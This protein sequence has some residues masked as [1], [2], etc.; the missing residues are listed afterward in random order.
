MGLKN[1]MLDKKVWAVIGANP[2]PS[3]F[4]YKIYKK[5]KSCGYT[6]YGVNANYSEVEGDKIYRSISELPEKPDCIDMVVRPSISEE[7]LDEIKE[8]GI[9]YVWFQPGTFD[10][11]VIKKAESLGLNTVY[12]NNAC[13]LVELR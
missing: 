8:N 10:D 13:V 12:K 6:V 5:L 3:R 2:D 4:G 1:T 7:Y 9:E 11:E